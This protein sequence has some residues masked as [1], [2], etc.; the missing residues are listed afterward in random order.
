M[1]RAL[2]Q[3]PFFSIIMPLYNHSAYVGEAIESVLNQSLGD[4][5]LVVCNDGSTDTSL[6]VVQSF[7]DDR[8]K[9]INKPNGGT[10]SAAVSRI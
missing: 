2:M 5:E 9:V 3:Q 7:K 10:V 6:E 1:E 4:F 8:I